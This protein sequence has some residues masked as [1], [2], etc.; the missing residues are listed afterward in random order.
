[1]AG[2]GIRRSPTT[3]AAGLILSRE[4]VLSRLRYWKQVV[5]FGHQLRQPLA[6][7]V[8]E[9]GYAGAAVIGTC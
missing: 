9:S 6:G 5:V 8:R 2:E 3:E 4:G 7:V 1:M